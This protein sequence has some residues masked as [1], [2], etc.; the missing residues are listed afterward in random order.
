[1]RQTL[2]YQVRDSSCGILAQGLPAVSFNKDSLVLG[3]TLLEMSELNSYALELLKSKTV[4]M[5][6]TLLE[7]LLGAWRLQVGKIQG[8]M[9]QK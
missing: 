6:G 8:I 9:Q 4:C 7:D 2:A 1:M 3:Y 5:R